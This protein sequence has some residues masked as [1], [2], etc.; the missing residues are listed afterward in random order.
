[1]RVLLDES[2]PRQLGRELNGHEASTVVR[3]GWAGYKNGA[4][5][6]AA[7]A[8]GFH[9]LLTADR[10]LEHQQNI[11]KSEL[12]LIV[13]EAVKNRM[14]ELAPLIPATLRALESIKAGD[15]V[16]ISAATQEGT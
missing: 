15:I 4:L 6:S 10:N 5:L 7:K 8:A 11:A 3:E 1:M 12:A 16:R 13:L 2:L 14:Q 9:V